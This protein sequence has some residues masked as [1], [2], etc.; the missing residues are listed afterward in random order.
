MGLFLSSLAYYVGRKYP[1]SELNSDAVREQTKADPTHP[2]PFFCR[3]VETT[4]K[5]GAETLRKTLIKWREQSEQAVDLIIFCSER[6][7]DRTEIGPEFLELCAEFDLSHTPIMGVG[8]NN[9]GNLGMALKLASYCLLDSDIHVV[10]IV[11]AD[12]TFDDDRIVPMGLGILSDG[13]GSMIVSKTAPKEGYKCLGL[14]YRSDRSLAPS[15]A[16]NSNAHFMKGMLNGILGAVEDAKRQLSDEY[17]EPRTMICPSIHLSSIEFISKICRLDF[18]NAYT[19]NVTDKSHV[20]SADLIINLLD[21]ADWRLSKNAH[22]API[23]CLSM[24]PF[25]CCAFIIEKC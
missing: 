19:K 1:I 8:S 14:G 5:M 6:D 9:C 11:T 16:S 22:T 18:S 13:G 24:S 23:L 2:V 25:S 21:S 15:N 17:G 4:S 12:R 7:Y 10:A 20:F 3:S